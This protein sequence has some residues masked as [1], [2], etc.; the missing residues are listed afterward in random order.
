MTFCGW[1][2]KKGLYVAARKKKMPMKM[3]FDFAP[4]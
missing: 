4:N 2:Q 3:I 1:G